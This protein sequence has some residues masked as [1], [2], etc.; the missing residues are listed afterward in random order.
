[1][2]T[3]DSDLLR[4]ESTSP[5]AL[6]AA[7]ATAAR[8]DA[9]ID[10]IE[11]IPLPED[12][13]RNGEAFGVVTD[14]V[15]A[16]PNQ[17]LEWEFEY[18]DYMGRWLFT[19]HHESMG[20]LFPKSVATLGR[21][22]SAYPYMLALFVAP[23]NDSRPRPLDTITAQSLGNSVSLG[24]L[25]GPAG[26]SFLDAANLTDEQVDALLGRH[27]PTFPYPITDEWV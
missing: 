17:R 19:C 2:S 7:D 11:T 1:M 9:T 20:Q 23:G 15:T 21:R 13:V 3:S 10:V 22:Y 12:R 14:D 16:W 5:R 6:A 4:D 8:D 24:V 26:G 25:P 18:N 27:H